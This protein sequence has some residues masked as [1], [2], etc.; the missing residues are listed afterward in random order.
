M[1][2]IGVGSDSRLRESVRYLE[3]AIYNLLIAFRAWKEYSG[4]QDVK[5]REAE[6]EQRKAK[7]RE[8]ARD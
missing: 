8:G 2:I 6:E 7:L 5:K 4:P 3:Q 1:T